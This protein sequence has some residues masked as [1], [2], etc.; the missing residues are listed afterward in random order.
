[1][2]LKASAHAFLSPVTQSSKPCTHN[3]WDAHR[4]VPLRKLC[5]DLCQQR[6]QG[7]GV[8][9]R[10]VAYAGEPLLQGP[11]VGGAL[12]DK[13]L[14]V[15]VLYA[16]TLSKR[17]RANAR[18]AEALA[19]SDADGPP[20]AGLGVSCAICISPGATAHAASRPDM[21]SRA[22]RR[23]STAWSA[24]LSLPSTLLRIFRCHARRMC[25]RHKVRAIPGKTILR[26]RCT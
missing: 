19:L 10:C 15:L 5:P 9:S 22:T 11:R 2:R 3:D 4:S 12:A 23:S 20:R 1:M 26:A 16:T 7:T 13:G 14:P 8:A 21:Y 25:R 6:A 18:R 24:V 17:A